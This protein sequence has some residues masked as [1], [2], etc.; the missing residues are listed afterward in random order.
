MELVKVVMRKTNNRKIPI[1]STESGNSR[2]SGSRFD[3]ISDNG[4][5][6][7]ESTNY[8]DIEAAF[9]SKCRVHG[10]DNSGATMKVNSRKKTNH[11]KESLAASGSKKNMA[12]H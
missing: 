5:Q 4:K 8:V 2:T 7:F 6:V 12:L 9:N 1:I 3:V 11:M 10:G